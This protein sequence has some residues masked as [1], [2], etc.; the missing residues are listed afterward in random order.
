MAITN[1]REDFEQKATNLESKYD[2]KIVSLRDELELRR[3]TEVHEVEEVFYIC[4]IMVLSNIVLEKE[5]PN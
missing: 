3:K 2:Q 5:W 1:M 4:I